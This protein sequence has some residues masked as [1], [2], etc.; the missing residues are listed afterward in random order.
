MRKQLSLLISSIF[1]FCISVLETK[2]TYSQSLYKR[3]NSTA[4]KVDDSPKLTLADV[5]RQVEENHPKLGG[6]EISKR[7]AEAK[8]LEKRGAFDPVFSV[9][10]DF[11]RYN[12]T[13]TPGKASLAFQNQSTVEWTNRSGI[14]FFAGSR[15]NFGSVKSPLSSTGRAG[16]YFAG[17]AV[18]L[19]RNR[20]I[21]SKSIGER[22]AIVDVSIAGTDIVETRLGL[23]QN[24]SASYWDWVAAKQKLEINRNLFDIAQER[25]KQVASRVSNGE[26]PPIDSA[27]AGLEVQR[28]MGNIVKADLELQKAAL[29]LGLYLWRA[30]GSP[31]ETLKP[32]SAPEQMSKPDRI[33]DFIIQE[34]VNRALQNRPELER[35]KLSRD[36]NELDIQLAQNERKPRVDL[37]LAPGQDLGFNG[38][39]TSFKFGATVELPLRTRTAD[40]QLAASRLKQEKIDLDRQIARQ[41]ITTEIL[42]AAQAVNNAH[43]RYLLALQELDLNL[44]L[45]N[46]ERT[47]FSVGDSTLF[48]VNQRERATAETR[49]KLIDIQTE[50]ELALIAFKIASMEF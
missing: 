13:S 1:I 24:A 10:S 48:L 11:L 45:E 33:G 15:N 50:Y 26:L 32:E 20:G 30:D 23:L 36:R 39:G 35:L 29:K 34:S 2:E 44:S 5:I 49:I 19:I 6:A 41:N 21:N 37:Y 25:A 43:D 4:A 22:Q 42:T 16:E 14:K 17:V 47:R 31:E 46:G 18:P 40:G 28:R 7:I 9:S 3:S 8:L 12:S 27:E 38:I